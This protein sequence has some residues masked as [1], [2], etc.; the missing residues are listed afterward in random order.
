MLDLFVFLYLLWISAG[1]WFPC[2]LLRGSTKLWLQNLEKYLS[3]MLKIAQTRRHLSRGNSIETS[4]LLHS[5]DRH[6]RATQKKYCLSGFKCNFSLFSLRQT[7]I[8][9]THAKPAVRHLYGWK[10]NWYKKPTLCNIKKYKKKLSNPWV[11]TLP[12]YC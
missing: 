10:L 8:L 9:G 6:A 7:I 12:N 1:L 4:L 2:L 11:Q 5:W 3:L